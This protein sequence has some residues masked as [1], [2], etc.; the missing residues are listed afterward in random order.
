MMPILYLLAI[1]FLAKI[2]L[3]SPVGKALGEAIRNLVPPRA[4]DGARIWLGSRNLTPEPSRR[5]GWSRAKI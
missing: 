3:D 1:V 2:V 5:P 4:A